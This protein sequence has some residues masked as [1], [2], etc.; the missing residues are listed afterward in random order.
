M[1]EVIK[2]AGICKSGGIYKG[3]PHTPTV[4]QLEGYFANRYWHGRRNVFFLL[5]LFFSHPDFSK[6]TKQLW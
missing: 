4:S 2:A 1:K 6:Q 3:A 5:L